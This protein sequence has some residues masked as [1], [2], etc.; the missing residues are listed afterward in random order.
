MQTHSVDEKCLGMNSKEDLLACCV[1]HF[2]NLFII[3]A[4]CGYS[5][6]ILIL[7]WFKNFD[8]GK[9][10]TLYWGYLLGVFWARDGNILFLKIY[11]SFFKKKIFYF[12]FSEISKI[13]IYFL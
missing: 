5:Q 11:V 12:I 4:W 2:K 7:K 6:N 10:T 3:I 9:S 13:F 8:E 1:T